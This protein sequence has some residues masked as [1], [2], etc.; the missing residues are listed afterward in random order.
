MCLIL[1]HAVVWS[2]GQKPPS[3]NTELREREVEREL[4]R[5][6]EESLKN[7]PTKW[8]P[9]GGGGGGSDPARREF[10]PVK[11]DTTSNTPPRVRKASNVSP[12]V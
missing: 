9:T 2:P 12:V 7:M 4:D 8:T 3:L 10:R 5:R 6:Q 1:L 11:L